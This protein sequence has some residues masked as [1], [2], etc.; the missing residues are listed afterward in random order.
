LTTIRELENRK[1]FGT[2]KGQFSPQPHFFGYE[3]RA[4]LPSNFD[5]SY[6][7]AIGLNA[8]LLAFN[9]CTGYMSC[10][11]NLGDPDPGKWIASGCPI[12]N[13][14]EI[15]QHQGKPRAQIKKGLVNLNGPMLKSYQAVRSKWALLDCYQS[16]GPI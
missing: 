5:S 6:C 7:Y 8:A 16:P 3:G 1:R 9:N 10:I 15:G 2:Y 11:K 4:A 13:M 14:M 12:L